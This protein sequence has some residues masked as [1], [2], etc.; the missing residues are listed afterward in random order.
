M[1]TPTPRVSQSGAE[2]VSELTLRALF[3]RE[4]TPLLRYAFALSGRREVAEEIVQEVFLQLHIRWDEVES[5]RAW[6]FRS[7]R[8]RVYSHLRDN[9]R[10]VDKDGD[11]DRPKAVENETPEA[12]VQRWEVAGTLREILDELNETDRTLVK[13]KYFEGLRYRDISARTGLSVSNVGYR[14]HHILK[15]IAERLRPLGIDG[16]S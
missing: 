4:E 7:V 16:T 11:D 14:L 3:D 13:L 10:E 6:L 1:L 15:G 2:G 9:R 8:N 12:L 5:P